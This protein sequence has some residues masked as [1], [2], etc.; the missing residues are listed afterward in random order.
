MKYE[1]CNEVIICICRYPPSHPRRA[2]RELAK[3]WHSV[4]I[5]LAPGSSLLTI[6]LRSPYLH[7]VSQKNMFFWLKGIT[8]RYYIFAAKRVFF[9]QWLMTGQCDHWPQWRVPESQN[10]SDCLPSERGRIPG[11]DSLRIARSKITK[12]MAAD[13]ARPGQTAASVG[14]L[15][16]HTGIKLHLY[17]TYMN[18]SDERYLLMMNSFQYL[19][20]PLDI[21]YRTYSR[22]SLWCSLFYSP[23]SKY[24]CRVVLWGCPEQG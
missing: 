7:R 17:R 13:I 22:C 2:G 19:V 23:I 16:E 11:Q 4:C 8:D 20:G 5:R 10:W 18:T 14:N 12:F 9:P 15:W 1:Y 24:H 3:P 21:R 6:N